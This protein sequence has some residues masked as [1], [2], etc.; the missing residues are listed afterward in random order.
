[1]TKCLSFFKH[2]SR[3]F[4]RNNNDNN[5]NNNNTSIKNDNYNYNNKFAII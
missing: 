3:L 1:M 2:H 4:C 5:N